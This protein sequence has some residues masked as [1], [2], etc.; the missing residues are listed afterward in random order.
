LHRTTRASVD[1]AGVEG[2]AYSYDGFISADGRFVALGSWASNLD[3]VA[4]P[5]GS[6]GVFMHDRQTPQTTRVSVDTAGTPGNAASGGAVL[7]A[8]GRFVAF[9]SSADNLVPG[10]TNRRT[11]VFV[12]D[13]LID[14][15]VAADLAITQTAS[16]DPFLPRKPLTYTLSVDNHGPDAAEGVTVVDTP[17]RQVEVVS[18][19]STQGQ[20]S[21]GT[22]VVCDLGPLS[23]GVG[24]TVT[25]TVKPKGRAATRLSNTAKVNAAPDDP[26]I[27]NNSTWLR[28]EAAP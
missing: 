27:R 4:A 22:P 24:T 21:Q 28:T 23:A 14:R 20:C 1:S 17:S 6:P 7:S 2:N 9:E 3:P 8:D 25:V 15:S 12:R 5:A 26:V 13:R 16:P 18:A 19:T 11:D 10:D